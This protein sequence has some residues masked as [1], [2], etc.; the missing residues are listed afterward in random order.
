MSQQTVGDNPQ[1]I[2]TR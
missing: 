1:I 2:I